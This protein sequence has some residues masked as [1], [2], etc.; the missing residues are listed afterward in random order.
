MGFIANTSC[1]KW[2]VEWRALKELNAK[3]IFTPDQIQT[4]CDKQWAAINPDGNVTVNKD[5]CKQGVMDAVNYLG[6]IGD[7]LTW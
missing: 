5:Q 6:S 7:G 3:G 1:G 4:A 2:Y